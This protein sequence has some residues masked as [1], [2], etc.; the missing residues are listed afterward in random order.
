M[1]VRRHATAEAF[2]TRSAPLLLS[3]EADHNLLL[4]LCADL[5]HDP[6]AFGGDD[7]YLA[8]VEE[9]GAV[10]AAALRTPPYGLTISHVERGGALE[11]LAADVG[12][13]F[14]RL[15][16][17]TGPDDVAAR[18]AALWQA[19]SGQAYEHA[20]SMRIY[21]LT[22]VRPVRPVSGRPRRATEA[23][24]A[25]VIAWLGA[26]QREAMGETSD[27]EAEESARRWLTSESRALYL[28]E[29]PAP[30]EGRPGRPVTVAGVGGPT[31]NGIRVSA[32]YTPPE[33]RRRGYAT[34]CVAAIS[35]MEL[36]AGRQ[37]VFLFTDL[38]NPTSNHIYQEIGYE[39]VCDFHDYRFA[40]D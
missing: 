35:Q 8:T 36:D 23:D 5:R 38:A 7:P 40:G 12:A 22:R 33:L 31:P 32:V 30:G 1:E 13:L 11:A 18:F 17:V 10:V 24:R 37:F 27:S 28:W 26:F 39:P 9:G 2:L 21:R 15:P 19:R 3:R 16:A 20:R 4:G 29:D 34:A 14:D 6:H 25:I